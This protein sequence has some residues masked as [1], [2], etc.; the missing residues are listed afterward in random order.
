MVPKAL[1]VRLHHMY[2][3]VNQP[4]DHS[5]A[6]VHAPYVNVLGALIGRHKSGAVSGVHIRRRVCPTSGAYPQYIFKYEGF[7]ASIEAKT[8]SVV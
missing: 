8:A 1:H 6:I 2:P 7:N 3:I 5:A 4:A